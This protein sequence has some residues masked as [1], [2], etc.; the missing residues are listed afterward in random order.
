MGLLL[1][2]IKLIIQVLSF[3]KEKSKVSVGRGQ[4]HI[5]RIHNSSDNGLLLF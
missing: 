4:E 2:N 3:P 5:L 1:L